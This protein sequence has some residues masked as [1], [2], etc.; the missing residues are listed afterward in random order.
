MWAAGTSN[1]HILTHIPGV[2]RGADLQGPILGKISQVPGAY[3]G[4]S[5]GG[6]APRSAKQAI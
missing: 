1:F 4:L 6:G 3:P 5:E 2:G